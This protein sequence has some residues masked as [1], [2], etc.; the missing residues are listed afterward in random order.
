[1]RPADGVSRTRRWLIWLGLCAAIGL[2][3]ALASNT[4]SRWAERLID[5]HA[6][7][8]LRG[9]LYRATL[10]QPVLQAVL[11]DAAGEPE[12]RF[13]MQLALTKYGAAARPV[14]E[15]FGADARLHDLL[16]RFGEPVVPVIGY[17]LDNDV[18]TLWAGWQMSRMGRAIK[19]QAS[20]LFGGA[21]D[22]G[23]DKPGS[24][25]PD[26]AAP[27]AADYSPLAR[28]HYAIEQIGSSGYQFLAQFAVDDAGVAHWNQT[29]RVLKSVEDFFAG[30]LRELE[31]KHD[32]AAP[33]GIGDVA[34]AGADVLTMAGFVK[35]LKL[36]NASRASAK[37]AQW[38]SLA[39]ARAVL[40][41]RVLA[42][43]GRI[44]R[45]ALKLGAIAGGTYLVMR[46][47]GL[48]TSLFVEAGGWLGLPPW[49]AA[50]AGWW[51]VA[52]LLS[53]VLLPLLAMISAL[54]PALARVAC[55]AR[56][57]LGWERS[58]R[59]VHATPASATHEG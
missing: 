21:N 38:A 11:L 2:A 33:I 32:M 54:N 51:V 58:G 8:T 3:I 30:G 35:V 15:A 34:V 47:P 43:S 20:S 37:A 56:W 13:K 36:L 18:A 16:R 24:K 42:G 41:R 39:E 48:L 49:V 52:L 12:L 55:A 27:P 57:V 26:P 9:D 23:G 46:H 53:F 40:G 25:P 4:T 6:R 10:A 1:M 31:T 17:F 28:G 19:A 14:L 29:D 44:G 50:A 59:T 7:Q 22:S 45:A 5:I